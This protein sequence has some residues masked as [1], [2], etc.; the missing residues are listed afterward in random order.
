M[1]ANGISFQDNCTNRLF[2]FRLSPSR[3]VQHRAD[4]SE[5]NEELVAD[6]EQTAGDDAHGQELDKRRCRPV[7][8]G[9]LNDD[10]QRDV[11]EI[12]PVRRI[13]NVT[14]GLAFTGTPPAKQAHQ[15]K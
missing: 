5:T 15:A 1:I 9:I 3:A 13:R 10:D 7:S 6:Q 11:C 14:H 2:R 4:R 12:Q 8:D